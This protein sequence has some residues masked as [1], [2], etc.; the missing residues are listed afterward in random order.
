MDQHP[1]GR[2]ILILWKGH[3]TAESL[4]SEKELLEMPSGGRDEE[5]SERRALRQQG[6]VAVDPVS[7]LQ[8]GSVKQH[9]IDDPLTWVLTAEHQRQTL[10]YWLHETGMPI[11]QMR[12]FGSSSFWWAF[13]GSHHRGMASDMAAT[14]HVF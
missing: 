5:R 13:Y 14:R 9:P 10:L 4:Q 6:R 7:P 11:K 8:I 2:Q 1:N 12:R 3:L